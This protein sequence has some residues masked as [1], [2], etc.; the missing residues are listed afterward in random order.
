MRAQKAKSGAER[1]RVRQRER[2]REEGGG[3][4]REEESTNSRYR[5]LPLI[6]LRLHSDSPFQRSEHLSSPLE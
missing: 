5:V 6:P 3:R 4:E 1:R 2:E